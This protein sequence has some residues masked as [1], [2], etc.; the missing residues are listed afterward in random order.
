MTNTPE[1]LSAYEQCHEKTCFFLHMEKQRCRICCAESNSAPDQRLCFPYIDST[2]PLI[3]KSAISSLLPSTVAVQPSLCQAWSETPKTRFSHD[4]AH[5]Q[6]H[7][8]KFD[9]KF[10]S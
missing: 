5:I 4:A 3:P 7:I 9:C 6:M 1:G 8:K 2:I 10:C